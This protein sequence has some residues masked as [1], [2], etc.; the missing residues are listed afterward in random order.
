MREI[1]MKIECPECSGT[2]VYS[3]MGESANT[4]LICRRCDGTGAYNYVYHYTE[5]TGR[6]VKEGIKRVYK[7]G[8]GYK[9]GLGVINFGGHTEIDMDKEGVSYEEFLEGKIIDDFEPLSTLTINYFRKHGT[10]GMPER[11]RQIDLSK[12][13]TD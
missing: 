6:K 12:V 5:F 2:G 8:C 13:S 3:G 10:V 4:A 11:G 7:D 1:K 9:I